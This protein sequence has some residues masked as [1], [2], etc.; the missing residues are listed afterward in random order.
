VM[1]PGG[2]HIN[3]GK[4]A[5]YNVDVELGSW[6]NDFR[7]IIEV[8][9]LHDGTMERMIGTG[10]LRHEDAVDMDVVGPAARAS[11]IFRD[12]RHV[13]PY[14][15]YTKCEFNIPVYTDGDVMARFRVR[16]DE[17]EQSYRLIRQVLEKVKT[18]DVAVSMGP[19]E[20][21][22]WGI[23]HVE[24]PRG[25]NIHWLMIGSDNRILRY[26]IRSASYANWP[27]V[28]LTAH[29]NIILDFPLIN[30]SFELCYACCDR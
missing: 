11:G 7:Q 3:P 29:G 25:D 22:R 5:L 21:G 9:L 6:I 16:I 24:S 18:G 27:A 2:L 26:R 1:M 4:M 20:E 19:L 10:K 23:G 12:I 8:I 15:A 13:L 28:P 30:K 17:I 14:G